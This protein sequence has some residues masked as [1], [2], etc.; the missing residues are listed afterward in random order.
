LTTMPK[1]INK[2]TQ[3]VGKSIKT[4]I[5]IENKDNNN[6]DLA[7]Q[8]VNSIEINQFRTQHQR[9]SSRYH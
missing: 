8:M 7:D 3:Q 6:N 5:S 2:L 1:L 9:H 4:R